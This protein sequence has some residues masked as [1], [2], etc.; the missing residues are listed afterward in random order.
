MP[1]PIPILLLCLLYLIAI[2]YLVCLILDLRRKT[3]IVLVCAFLSINAFAFEISSVHLHAADIFL[4]SLLLSCVGVYVISFEITAG[5]ALLSVALFF[6]SFGIYPASLIIAVCLFLL[7]ALKNVYEGK[8]AG[9]AGKV[10]VWILA[11]LFAGLA[12]LIGSRAALQIMKLE[13]ATSVQSMF[14]LS[15]LSLD[16]IKESA[17]INYRFFVKSIFFNKYYSGDAGVAATVLL[18]AI[19]LT[20]FFNGDLFWCAC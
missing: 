14:S 6:I 8:T 15:S 3:E 2:H 18:V 11:G 1:A 20:V 10:S 13:P 9:L 5:K 7:L 12:Y 4:L 17:V 19:A 16:A